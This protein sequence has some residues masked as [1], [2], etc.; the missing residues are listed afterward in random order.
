MCL[1][2]LWDTLLHIMQADVDMNS[3]INIPSVSSI[4]VENKK[5]LNIGIDFD[6]WFI[7]VMSKVITPTNQTWN[8]NSFRDLWLV[9]RFCSWALIGRV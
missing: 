6:D 1:F 9:S 8:D 7:F 5:V 2:V 3:E 4:K